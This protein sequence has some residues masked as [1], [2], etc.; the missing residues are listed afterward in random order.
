MSYLALN[1]SPINE[2]ENE[3]NYKRQPRNNNNKTIKKKAQNQKIAPNV[4]NMIQSVGYG[5]GEHNFDAMED[6]NA[7]EPA[8]FNPPDYAELTKLPNNNH[9]IPNSFA[10]LSAESSAQNVPA[11][12]EPFN[13]GLTYATL[14][15]NNTYENNDTYVRPFVPYYMNQ[16]TDTN[17]KKNKDPLIEKLNYMI[18]LLEEQQNDR[19]D[20]ITEEL[21]LYFFLGIFM[22]FMVDSFARS[23]KYTR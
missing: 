22:I 15:K 23:G 9:A 11:I 21:I 10:S 16:M 8:D 1:P 3:G 12:K 20:H 5:S 6:N 18:L 2:N 19:T 17:E 7:D 14:P 4:Q 13:N